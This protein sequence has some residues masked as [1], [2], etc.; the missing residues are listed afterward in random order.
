MT[1]QERYASLKQYTTLDDMIIGDQ[2]RSE[3]QV[4]RDAV[5]T[6][7]FVKA[8]KAKVKGEKSGKA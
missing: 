3:A 4:K 7:R 5:K 6:A 8:H 1:D 2:S